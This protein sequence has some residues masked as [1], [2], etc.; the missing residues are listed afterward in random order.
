MVEINNM[1]QA[2][3]KATIN[4][5]STVTLEDRAVEEKAPEE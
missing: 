1:I 5:S 3:E 4:L 2:L